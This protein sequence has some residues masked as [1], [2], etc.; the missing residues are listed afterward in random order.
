MI[1]PHPSPQYHFG[2]ATFHLHIDYYSYNEERQ[3]TRKRQRKGIMYN[4]Y[5]SNHLDSQ[6]KMKELA[7]EARSRTLARETVKN[8][9][10]VRRSTLPIALINALLIFKLR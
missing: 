1:H 5:Y 8:V 3:D 4:S 7:Q 2:G 10:S 6:Q 9:P